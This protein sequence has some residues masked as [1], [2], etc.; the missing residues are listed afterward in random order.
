MSKPANS[1]IKKGGKHLKTQVRQRVHEIMASS[2]KHPAKEVMK[3]IETGDIPDKD[4]AKLWLELLNYLEPKLTA[5]AL[6]I[7]DGRE[8][9]EMII[10]VTPKS[11][12]ELLAAVEAMEGEKSNG[13]SD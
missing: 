6:T 12:E 13:T 10:D 8:Q 5:Q 11:T 7:D 3:L 9:D 2:G 4:K 1:G